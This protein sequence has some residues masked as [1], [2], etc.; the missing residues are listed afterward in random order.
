MDEIE[1]KKKRLLAGENPK[2]VKLELA[3]ELVRMYHSASLADAAQKNWERTF[4]EK[5]IPEALQEIKI[6]KEMLLVDFLVAHE[7]ADSKSSA[8]RLIEEGAIRDMESDEKLTNLQ[9]KFVR[10]TILKI[11]KKSF[12]KVIV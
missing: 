7:F 8:R 2:I 3:H 4:S 9:M 1:E 10:T 6:K 11:G 5:K 12:A